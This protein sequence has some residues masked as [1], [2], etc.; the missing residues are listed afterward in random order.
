MRPDVDDN[1]CLTNNY[2]TYVPDEAIKENEA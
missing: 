2:L 1:Y